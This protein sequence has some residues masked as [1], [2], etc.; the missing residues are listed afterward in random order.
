MSFSVTVTV[1]NVATGRRWRISKSPLKSQVQNQEKATD[2]YK[3][4]R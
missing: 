1:A 4:T 3:I 2:E